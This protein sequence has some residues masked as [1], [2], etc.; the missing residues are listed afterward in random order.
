MS[1]IHLVRHGETDHN[2]AGQGLGRSN[3][4]LTQHGVAQAEAVAR[5]LST[6][7]IQRVLASPLD[8][9]SHVARA[10]AAHHGLD[11]ETIEA[12]VELDVGDTEGLEIAETRRRYPE[13]MEAWVTD[14]G[15]TVRMPGGESL[16][17]LA[18]RLRPLAVQLLEVT[19][20]DLVVVSHNFALRALL[21]ELL[22]LG[23]ERWRAFQLDLASVSSLTIRNGRVSVR[24]L[25]DTC[26][27]ASLNLA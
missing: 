2:R 27:L 9:A 26:H 12:L 23:L 15:H 6:E 5:R 18:L 8:R 19:D 25:N 21:C 22:G 7:P 24:A 10:I 14:Q 11:L 4:G 20:G 1:T 16:D 17:D 13:F 3:V